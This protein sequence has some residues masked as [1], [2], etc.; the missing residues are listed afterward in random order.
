MQLACLAGACGE[1]QTDEI[2]K[3]PGGPQPAPCLVPA[4]QGSTVSTGAW[5]K[6][7]LSSAF[8]GVRASAGRHDPPPECLSMREMLSIMENVSDIKKIIYIHNT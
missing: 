6:V 1:S 5:G 7:N 2:G 4:T 8:C 3:A